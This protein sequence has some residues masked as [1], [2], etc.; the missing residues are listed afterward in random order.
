MRMRA[1]FLS[2]SLLLLFLCF[3]AKPLLSAESGIPGLHLSSDQIAEI[4]SVPT[5]GNFS[6]LVMGDNSCGEQVFEYLV[7]MANRFSPSFI[8][9]TGDIVCGDDDEAY[10]RFVNS[11][12]K[13]KAPYLTVVGNHEVGKPG[14]RELYKKYLGEFEY[15]FDYGDARFIIIDNYLSVPLG[16]Y[17]VITDEQFEWLE[18]KLKTDK[19]KMIFMHAPILTRNWIVS[20]NDEDSK[21]LIDLCDKY[22]VS[23][24]FFGHIHIYD[25]LTRGDTDYV[26]TGGSGEELSPEKREYHSPEGGA[27]YNMVYVEV[28]DGMVMDYVIKIKPRSLAALG[29]ERPYDSYRNVIAPVVEDVKIAPEEPGANDNV[30]VAAKIY[31]DCEKTETF[32]TSAEVVYSLDNEESWK[33]TAMKKD[34][35]DERIW[36][37]VIPAQPSGTQ[38]KYY[39]RA[40][41]SSGNITM[42]L[43]ASI[44]KTVS[45][46]AGEQFFLYDFLSDMDDPPPLG[47]ELDIKSV[48]V[49]YDGDNI[50]GKIEVY[51]KISKGTISP[52]HINAYGLVM[53]DEKDEVDVKEVR[54]FIYAPLATALGLP[55]LGVF[56]PS[57]AKE[58]GIA[59]R[60]ANKGIDM[61]LVEPL[62]VDMKAFASKDSLYMRC[63]RDALENRDVVKIMPATVSITSLQ[64]IAVHIG[65]ATPYILLYL[66]EPHEYKVR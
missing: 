14:K 44:Q 16:R 47:D 65:D 42:E 54:L 55:Q 26:V 43:P 36:R 27:F 19:I 32:T 50:F 46:E 63:S 25:K 53:L 12:N 48:S 20:M 38:V 30:T 62:D 3:F 29:M 23:K 24:V 7:E 66:R 4:K 11:I 41:D 51:G 34:Y 39:L 59:E 6:F 22:N 49:G 57:K 10:E 1:K 31:N 35:R 37:G 17:Q 58:E 52:P 5:D 18:D 33:K 13:S 9:N 8:I 21:R 56:I 60:H 64:T 15:F 40:V 45:P 28:R 61:S 2:L